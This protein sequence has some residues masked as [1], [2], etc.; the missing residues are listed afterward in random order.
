MSL[1]TKS[2]PRGQLPYLVDGDQVIGDSDAIIAYL[3]S[4]YGLPIDAGLTDAQRNLD[5]LIGA[6][7]TISTGSCRIHGGVIPSSGPPSAM[8]CCGRIR[9]S[10][11]KP[12]SCAEIQFRAVS[13]PGDRPV[14]AR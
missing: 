5:L 1:D 4:R 13:L 10:A 9:I 14:R 6:R 11:R 3:K 8:R 2:A 12:G 7:S